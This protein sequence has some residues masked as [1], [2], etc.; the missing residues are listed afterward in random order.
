MT[1]T[2]LANAPATPQEKLGS[3]LPT[4][5]PYIPSYIIHFPRIDSYLLAYTEDG[6]SFTVHPQ[7]ARVFVSLRKAEGIAK[8]FKGEISPAPQPEPSLRRGIPADLSFL[9]AAASSR[10][11]TAIEALASCIVES[12]NNAI[13]V[14]IQKAFTHGGRK[15]PP[16]ALFNSKT[17]GSTLAL[18]LLELSTERVRRMVEESDAVFAK[19]QQSAAA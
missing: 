10:N 2:S 11:L 5:P 9:P 13:W 7:N 12:A 3:P 8:L 4:D 6:C 1:Q 16:L 15:T 14:G 18:P 17:T 19:A